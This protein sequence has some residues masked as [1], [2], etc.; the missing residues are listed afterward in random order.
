MIALPSNRKLMMVTMQH[1][2]QV[3]LQFHQRYLLC[4]T[5]NGVREKHQSTSKII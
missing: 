1:Q 5:L 3:L 2:N 4:V